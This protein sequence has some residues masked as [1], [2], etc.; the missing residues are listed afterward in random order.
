MNA[1]NIVD[2]L[3]VMKQIAITEYQSG[4]K[5][6]PHSFSGFDK[7]AVMVPF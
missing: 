5:Q 1:T 7:K 3:A 6:Y 4:L 2:V